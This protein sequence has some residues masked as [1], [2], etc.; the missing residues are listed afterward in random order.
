MENAAIRSRKIEAMNLLAKSLF[1]KPNA[2]PFIEAGDAARDAQ[3]W[4]RA[5]EAYGEALKLKPERADIW[6][7]LGHAR[8]EAGDLVGAEQAYRQALKLEPRVYET[9]VQMGHLRRLE[10]RLPEAAA[11][12]LDAAEIDPSQR[13]PLEAL[14]E[15]TSQG[16]EVD[17]ER[18]G[19][20]AKRWGSSLTTGSDHASISAQ[21]DAAIARLEPSLRAEN[22]ASIQALAESIRSIEAKLGQR[23]D[24]PKRVSDG[25]Q[26]VFDV[27][28]LVGFFNV[29]RLPTGIQRV[30]IEVISNLLAREGGGSNVAV[31]TFSKDRDLWSEVPADIFLRLCQ[32]SLESGD[33]ADETWSNAVKSLR[34]ITE[35]SPEFQFQ[36]GACLVNLGTSW[37]LQNYFLH[38]RRAKELYGV[39]Y[40]PFVHDMIPIM[41]PEHC[42]KELTQDFISWALGVFSHADHFLTNSEASKRDLLTVAEQLGHT[43]APQNIHVVRLNADF[44]K[45]TIS[46]PIAQTLSRYGLVEQQYVLFVSTVESRKN[47]LSAFKAWQDLIRRRGAGDVLK[48]ICVGNR[49]WLNDAV[50][51]KLEADKDLQS[52]VMIVSGVSDPDL[53]NLYKASAFTLYPSTYEGWG[54]PV[55]E[56]FCYG[57]AALLSDSSSLPEAGGNFADYFRVGDQAEFLQKLE[58]LMFD[59]PYRR[60]REQNIL[61]NFQPRPWRELGEDVEQQLLSW[62]PAG[63]RDA[64]PASHVPT[65]GRYYPLN[66]TGALA[67]HRT[68]ESG[69]RFRSGTGWWFPDDWGNWTKPEGG[70]LKLRFEPASIGEPKRLYVR[71]LGLSARSQPYRIALGGVKAEEGVLAPQQNLWCVVN[72]PIDAQASGELVVGLHGGE[73]DDFAALTDGRDTRKGGLGVFGFMICDADDLLSRANLVEAIALGGGRLPGLDSQ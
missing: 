13:Y 6:V 70:M 47:H 68:M 53:A 18:A 9:H 61:S 16:V 7:Q 1:K 26:I 59:L 54:L 66:R 10:K 65:L 29:A 64:L 5:A 4:L 37:W 56:S 49:G 12:Y 51:S 48:L 17:T 34:A 2:K 8:K 72:V 50:F 38:V 58:R 28:D 57:K 25:L 32:L 14:M 63:E 23:G 19:R 30:Q 62:F 11:H 40:V 39:R 3:N 73:Y 67:I 33:L 55:T 52:K 21:L 60:E 15:L 42:V 41:T 31:C 36:E 44:R 45:P 43:I 27:S 35:L 46:V 71:L 24:D 69:E 20:L 22:S